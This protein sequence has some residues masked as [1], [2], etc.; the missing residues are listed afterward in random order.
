MKRAFLLLH[1]AALLAAAACAAP[2]PPSGGI[3]RYRMPEEP[4]NLDPFQASDDMSYVF[5]Y[6]IFD[7]L[8]EFEPGSMAVRPAL[9]ESW[10]VSDDG[11]TYTF[12]LRDGI[13][14]HNGSPVGADDVVYTIRR[15]LTRESRSRKRSY[16]RAIEGSDAFWAGETED[17]AGVR[18][19]D[20]RTVRITLS[21][22]YSP[23]LQ[24]LASEAGSILPE[25]VYSD[26]NQAYLRHPVGA[27]PFRFESWEPS[28]SMTLSRFERHWKERPEAPI[29]GISFRFI[30]SA[31]TALEEYRA[32]NLDFTME[33]PPGQRALVMSEMPSHFHS[34]QRLAIFYIGF[35]HAHEPVKGNRALRQAM[36]HAIDRQFIVDVLQEG[37]D[38]LASGVLSP[39]MPGHDAARA[40]LGYDPGE[41]AR[42]LAEAGYPGGKGLPEIELLVHETESFRQTSERIVAD[43]TRAGMP[44]RLDMMDM[45]AYI[46][47][48]T[49]DP[50]NGP[51]DTLFNLT[52]FPDWPDPDSFL[53][54]QF[55]SDGGGNFG[56]Y[57]NPEFDALVHRARSEADPEVRAGLYRQ[58]DTILVDDAA[59]IPIYWYGQDILLS[60]SVGRLKLSPM[61]FHALAWEEMTLGG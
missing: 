42:R 11:R 56:R 31:S 1:V 59:L 9:A 61:G 33:I 4:S 23:F 18:A 41:S 5:I 38:T 58:A 15:A 35:N 2:E 6:P 17:L 39:G 47:A 37:K 7:G 55:A 24:V 54:E 26:P 48:L 3:L 19:V 30:E 51:P 29:Q 22:A 8:V 25:E 10:S 21:Y 43:L 20:P 14:F 34:G 50:V 13:R 32:G 27:G 45:G 57:A 49:S 40:P 12:T 28:I 36:I 52:W 53:A 16:F 60:P 46:E 44:V